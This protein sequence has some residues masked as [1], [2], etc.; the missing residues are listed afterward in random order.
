MKIDIAQLV[1]LIN[2]GAAGFATVK[3]ALADGRVTATEDKTQLTP[4][5]A[6]AKIDAAVAEELKTGDASDDNIKRRHPQND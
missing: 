2:A 3:K 1:G 5:Q 4:E 6:Q